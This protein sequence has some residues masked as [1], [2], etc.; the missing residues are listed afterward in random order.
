M[1]VR[2]K[3][4]PRIRTTAPIQSPVDQPAR[5][6]L[7][8]SL[9]Q[10]TNTAAS[11]SVAGIITS[12]VRTTGAKA[13]ARIAPAIHQRLRVTNAFAMTKKQKAAYGYASGSSTRYDEYASD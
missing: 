12:S 11:T 5:Q 6:R 10:A 8:P 2:R 13:A 7:A 1:A 4:A 9:D 3:I